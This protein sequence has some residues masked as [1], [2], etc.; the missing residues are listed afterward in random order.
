[1]RE[2]SCFWIPKDCPDGEHGE[3]N[4]SLHTATFCSSAPAGI[5]PVPDALHDYHLNGIDLWNKA[6]QS[7]PLYSIHIMAIRELIASGSLVQDE[8]LLQ[9]AGCSE[10]DRQKLTIMGRPRYTTDA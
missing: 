2:N 1:M 9:I 7:H 5:P 10:N 4:D 8:G 3:C 6:H